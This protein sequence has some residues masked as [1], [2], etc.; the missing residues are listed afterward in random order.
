MPEKCIFVVFWR[1][2]LFLVASYVPHPIKHW[3]E[4]GGLA[5]SCCLVF[6]KSLIMY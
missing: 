2:L 1:V 4:I 6:F 3:L 5:Y